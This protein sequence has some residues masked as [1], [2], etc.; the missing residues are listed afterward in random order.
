MATIQ[1]PVNEDKELFVM[2]WD[3]LD[4]RYPGQT[5][6]HST[7]EDKIF[8]Y[9]GHQLKVVEWLINHKIIFQIIDYE[10]LDNDFTQF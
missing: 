8:V 1:V 10:T 4:M 5:I 6:L 7:T 9:H 3:Y 2:I